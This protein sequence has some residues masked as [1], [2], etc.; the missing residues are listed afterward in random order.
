[1]KLQAF[2]RKIGIILPI[3][4]GTSALQAK[5]SSMEYMEEDVHY[6]AQYVH[7]GGSRY[8]MF[9]RWVCHIGNI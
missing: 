9:F 5:E 1:M 7:L 2:F 3:L 4:P 6:A 8:S